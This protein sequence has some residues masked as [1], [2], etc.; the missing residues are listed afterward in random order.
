MEYNEKYTG[1]GQD[2]TQG[3]EEMQE[4]EGMQT[5]EFTSLE[6]LLSQDIQEVAR[7]EADVSLKN[8]KLIKLPIR[9][10]GAEVTERIRKQCT[11]HVQ[12]RTGR[13]AELDELRYNCLLIAEGT[14]TTRTNIRWNDPALAKKVGVKTP[15]PE[16]VIPKVLSVGG[17]NELSLKIAA[18][19]GTNIPFDDMVDAAKN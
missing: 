17:I 16:F 7:G 6:D 9:A 10:V 18:L 13:F 5:I 1:E 8:G 19:S 11:R 15:A 4:Q 2:T 14:D 3:Q 12:T